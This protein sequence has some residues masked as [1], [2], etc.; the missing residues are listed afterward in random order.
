ML[1][2]GLLVGV[3]YLIVGFGVAKMAAKMRGGSVHLFD[4]VMW[5]LV[6][7]SYAVT[8]RVID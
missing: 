1:F 3:V 4:M 5:W 6:V 7:L 2:T 8:D